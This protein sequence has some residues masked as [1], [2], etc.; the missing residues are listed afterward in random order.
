MGCDIHLYKEKFIDGKWLTADEW[1]AYDYGD[2][3]KGQEVPYEKRYTG[4]NYNLFGI[5]SKGV[6]RDFDFAF[7]PRGLPF[8]PCPE[9]AAESDGWGGDGHSHSYLYLH[10][11][12]DMQ[13]FLAT[14]TI[15]ISGMKDR[16]ELDALQATIDA[17]APNWDLLYPYCQGTTSSSAVDFNIPVPASFITG[18]CLDS[19]IALFD[20]VDGDNHRIVLFFDN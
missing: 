3:D 14:H 12:K 6:R 15:P 4:R 9:I 20:G 2:D 16:D 18:A 5:L 1:R 17:G 8:N 10:E 13:A 19:I 11:L 7:E